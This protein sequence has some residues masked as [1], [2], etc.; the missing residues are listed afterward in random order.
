MRPSA[1]ACASG[2][3]RAVQLLE[4]WRHSVAVIDEVDIVLH[5]LRSELNWPLGDKYPL[6]FAP[7]RWQLPMVLLEAVLAVQAVPMARAATA[8]ARPAEASTG[9][10]GL[11]AL[12]EH[13]ERGDGDSLW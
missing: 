7:T 4:L 13:A 10:E 12:V 8:T 3:A 9:A 11:V 6:D 1:P 2:A 5:P